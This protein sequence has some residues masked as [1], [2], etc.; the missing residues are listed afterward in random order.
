MENYNQKNFNLE[1]DYD[2]IYLIKK[3]NNVIAVY[4]N[5]DIAFVKLLSLINHDLSI[6]K[7]LN[8]DQSIYDELKDY[9]ISTI[10][11]NS[12][13]II[14]NL[15]LCFSDFVFKDKD[16]K[17]VDLNISDNKIKNYILNKTIDIKN[18]IISKNGHSKN[19]KQQKYEEEE[20]EDLAKQ[21]DD[22][23][24]EQLEDNKE[25]V[26]ENKDKLNKDELKVKLEELKSIKE[27]QE[28][29][30]LS[31][32]E[33]EKEKEEYLDKKIQEKKKLEEKIKELK[34]KKEKLKEQKNIFDADV[35]IFNLLK[36]NI[37]EDSNFKIPELFLRKYEIFL[38]L[39]KKNNITFEEY[40]KFEPFKNSLKVSTEFNQMFE[41]SEN[42]AY[43]SD[44]SEYSDS[45]ESIASSENENI[46]I[47][48]EM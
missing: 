4:D 2:L 26:E 37:E 36:K 28:S 18:V 46:E 13:I 5:F 47:N 44:E 41:D 19:I 27:L 35:N 30:I 38:I 6:Y 45:S 10:I 25:E 40:L 23:L 12:D 48:D 17:I 22:D 9:N 31:N 21:L 14:N 43:I 1:C 7:T 42:I 20:E 34:I 39:D 29:I 24:A 3:K 8:L 32:K 16:D 11:K 15:K 33:K